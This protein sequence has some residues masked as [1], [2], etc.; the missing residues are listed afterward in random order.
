MSKIRIPQSAFQNPMPVYHLS[1]ELVFPSPYLATDEGLLAIGG[2]L[3]LKRLLLAYS[4]GIFPWYS[5]GEPILWWSP[6]PRLVL[7][8][9]ELKV[10][11]SLKKIIRQGVFQITIDCAFKEVISE[12]ARVRLEKHEGTWIVSD[13]IKA[14]C[15]L[16]ETGLAHSVEA[17]QDDRL[18]GG[19]Y[20][21]S[22]GRCFFGESMFTRRSN[23]SKVAIVAL[24]EHLK[25]L[26]FA[27][28]DCQMTTA[29]LSRFGAQE[30]SRSR[31]LNELA[32]ALR[33][34]TLKGK[35]SVT[36]YGKRLPFL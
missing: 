19:L 7:Y 2:D 28:I 6:D 35:W 20:G 34:P 18:A 30:I 24:V 16:H 1:E 27:F 32:S 26:D 14:Y 22:L 12:C 17:W 31:Y 13:M 21:V 4:N 9:D 25:P 29:H 23:A 10:S 8:P 11:R 15:R 36:E 5:E 33:Y 3:S